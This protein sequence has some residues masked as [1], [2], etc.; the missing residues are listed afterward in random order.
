MNPPATSTA[1]LF[2]RLKLHIGQIEPRDR[3]KRLKEL[4]KEANMDSD[5]LN[6]LASLCATL[7]TRKGYATLA[8]DSRGTAA[9]C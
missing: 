5:E 2:N 8:A 4:I 3:L 6:D 9:C 7:R 1:V